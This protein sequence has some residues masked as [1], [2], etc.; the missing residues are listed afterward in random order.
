MT[1]GGDGHMI[2]SLNMCSLLQ[3]NYAIE[4]AR[5]YTDW[6]VKP[7]AGSNERRI[8]S[9]QLNQNLAQFIADRTPTVFCRLNVSDNSIYAAYQEM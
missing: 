2:F 3:V 4:Q 5:K 1:S 8:I 6:R 7:N 9:I